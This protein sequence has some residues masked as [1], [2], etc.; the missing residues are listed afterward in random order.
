[1]KKRFTYITLLIVFVGSTAFF[2]LRNGIKLQNKTV[3]FY[4]LKERKGPMA[5][6]AEW[7][8]VKEKGNKLIR[9]VRETPDDKKSMLQLAT[10]YLQEGRATGDFAY[11]NEAALR[12]VEDVLNAE[13]G[14]FEALILKSVL[15]LSQHHFEEALQT[16][17]KAKA[18][19]PY[20]AYVY[21]LLA[22]GNIEMGN[23]QAAIDNLDKMVSIRPDL[24]SYSRISYIREIHG[25]TD[26]AIKAMAMAVDA[27]F[28]GDEGTEWARIQLAQL[29]ER[30][31]DLES[32]E[33][34]YSI[35]LEERPGY[36]YAIAGM[37]NIAMANKNYQKAISLYI[38]A[39]TLFQDYSF[40]EKLVEAYLLKGDTKKAEAILNGVITGFT[41]AAKAGEEEIGH[42]ADKELANLYLLQG[43]N[44]RALHHALK[45][46]NRRP[47]NIETAEAVAWAYYK[48]G[49]AEKAVS[50]L[51]T[52]MRTNS[53]NPTLLCHAALIYAQRGETTKAKTLLQD[54]LKSNPAV[55][56]L[57][58]KESLPLFNSL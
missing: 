30:T 38:Q 57:I 22:D 37:G 8:A 58:K 21:G 55:E 7:K 15:Q 49:D 50:F 33:M 52:A 41:E 32:A 17:K 44:A 43:N 13:P 45:E 25:E 34:N 6:T 12:Y 51:Q 35:A 26:A 27:G 42:H 24:R 19:N 4:P 20:N 39:D 40:K 31:G 9:I 28:P 18:I 56:S 47:N 14:N 5:E 10:V 29:Y 1:M 23:Y 3:A 46:Y 11:Y 36:A 53:K 16:A 54:V 48:N 2:V